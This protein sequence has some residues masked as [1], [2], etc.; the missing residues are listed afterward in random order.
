M[1]QNAGDAFSFSM[2]ARQEESLNVDIRLYPTAFLGQVQQALSYLSIPRHSRL[3]AIVEDPME[4]SRGLLGYF[5]SVFHLNKLNRKPFSDRGGTGSIGVHH[6]SSP[7]CSF[8]QCGGGVDH[9]AEYPSAT[10]TGISSTS[11]P[12]QNKS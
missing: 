8:N 7:G 1:L 12:L 2:C 6:Q 11:L 4:S 10:I 5:Y 9:A 3:Q